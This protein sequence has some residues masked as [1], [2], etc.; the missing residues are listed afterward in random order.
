MMANQL[1]LLMF[2]PVLVYSA[3]AALMTGWDRYW[4]KRG[5]Y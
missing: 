4:R 3:C 1:W 2:S 5:L